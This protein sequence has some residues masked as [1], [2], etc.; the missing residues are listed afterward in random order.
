MLSFSSFAHT[1]PLY[2]SDILVKPVSWVYGKLL[3]YHRSNTKR[4]VPVFL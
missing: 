2:C 4:K 3:M 1:C